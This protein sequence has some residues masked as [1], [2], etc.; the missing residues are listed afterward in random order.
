MLGNSVIVLQHQ[1]Q[2]LKGVLRRVRRDPQAEQ[3]G[4]GQHSGFQGAR[5]ALY[6]QLTGGH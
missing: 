5:Q 3:I 4:L 2:G 1:L 6:A